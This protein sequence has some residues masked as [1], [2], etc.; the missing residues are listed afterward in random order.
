MYFVFGFGRLSAIS[1]AAVV[2][3]SRRQKYSEAGDAAVAVAHA[4]AGDSPVV[5]LHNPFA[6]P[7]PQTSALG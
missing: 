6:D 4:A 5:F 1:R 7:E 2:R 3:P